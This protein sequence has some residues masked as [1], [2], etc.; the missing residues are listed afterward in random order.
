MTNSLLQAISISRSYREFQAV[1]PLDFNINAGEIIILTGPNGSGKSTLLYCLSGLLRPST[2]NVLV[3]GYDL[4]KKEVPAKQRLAFVP[5]VPRFYRELTTWEHLWFFSMAFGVEQ[6]WEQRAETLLSE[7]GLWESRNLF[8]HNLSRGMR[9]KLA[10]SQALIRPFKMLLM[11]EPTSA[12]DTDS[13]NL[14]R[15]KLLMIRDRGCAILLTSHDL[16]IV[17][18]LTGEAM[19]HGARSA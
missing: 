9:L 11:D 14:V 1:K 17:D 19:A 15:E 2:G 18:G 7:F 12:L 10:I 13:V 5:D 6:G 8:P 16:S 4:Y 3:E